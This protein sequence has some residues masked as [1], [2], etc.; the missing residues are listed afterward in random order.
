MPL[1]FLTYRCT[2]VNLVICIMK[3]LLRCSYQYSLQREMERHFT[4]RILSKWNILFLFNYYIWRQL[5][6]WLTSPGS[7]HSLLQFAFVLLLAHLSSRKLF[8]LS[9]SVEKGCRGNSMKFV[10]FLLHAPF[11]KS[12]SLYL[13]LL[14]N[15][16]SASK[17]NLSVFALT[18][19]CSSSFREI[20]AQL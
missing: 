12:V 5:L 18:V 14:C 4:Y 8:T 17:S 20:K 16:L 15:L 7:W 11:S 6:Y 3:M 9:P 2:S 19:F 1:H 13:L 10:W